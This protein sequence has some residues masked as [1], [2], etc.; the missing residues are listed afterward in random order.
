MRD[1]AINSGLEIFATPLE[2]LGVKLWRADASESP[3]GRGAL[4]KVMLRTTCTREKMPKNL[5]FSRISLE[6]QSVLRN[7]MQ[8]REAAS[9]LGGAQQ[10]LLT[11][12]DPLQP[13]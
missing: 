9:C 8:S 3:N 11:P 13:S 10:V 2:V 6:L 4:S 12:R 7:I 1:A 5:A